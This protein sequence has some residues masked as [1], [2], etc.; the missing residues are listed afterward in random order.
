VFYW[1]F[2]WINLKK[3]TARGSITTQAAQNVSSFKIILGR[4]RRDYFCPL[5]G[6]CLPRIVRSVSSNRLNSFVLIPIL[7]SPLKAATR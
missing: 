5:I 4:Y 1:I 2:C 3:Q 7:A 6:I